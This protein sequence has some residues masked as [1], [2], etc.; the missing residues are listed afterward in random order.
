MKYAMLVYSDQSSW[1]SLSEEEAARQ[2]EESMPRWVALFEEMGKADPSV[3][4]REL[5]SAAEAK[6]VTGRR[7]RD[8]RHRRPVRRDEGAARRRLPH[9]PAR[10]RRGDPHRR[11]R[12][13]PPS[14]ARLEI[15]PLGSRPVRDRLAAVY[16]GR[17]RRGASRS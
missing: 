8:D 1:A 2:R 10:P 9:R 12:P 17:S 16:A 3:Q 13:R 5:V 6:V 15:R 7:R 14:M 11:A 4:G